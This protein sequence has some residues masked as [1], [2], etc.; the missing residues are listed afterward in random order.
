[1]G[2]TE[3]FFFED[4][5]VAE[6]VARRL[7]GNAETEGRPTKLTRFFRLR[8][9]AARATGRGRGSR[10]TGPRSISRRPR[11]AAPRSVL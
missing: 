10:P 11:R 6:L 2:S 3:P 4:D 7:L 5:S 1:M 9:R 8:E